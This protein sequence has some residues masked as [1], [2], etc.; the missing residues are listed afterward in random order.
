MA[1]SKNE[2]DYLVLGEIQDE[3]LSMLKL[4]SHRCR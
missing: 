3:L 4:V 2:H 1:E